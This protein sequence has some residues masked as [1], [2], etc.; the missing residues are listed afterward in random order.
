MVANTR[1]VGAS[2]KD[3][4]TIASAVSWFQA[5]HNF[6]TDGIGTISI[7]DSAEF[8][9]R[10]VVDGIAG[11]PSTSAYLKIT[12]ALP[13]RHTGVAGTG[14]ARV[15]DTVG[16]RAF[17]IYTSFTMIE[18]L[19]I[20]S[21]TGG[22]SDEAIRIRPNVFDVLIT[23]NLLWTAR[24][25]LDQDGVY[26]GNW[27]MSAYVDNCIIYGW[28]RAGI[29]MQNYQGSAT[30]NWYIDH[31]TVYNCGGEQTVDSGG[32]KCGTRLVAQ[33]IFANVY[34]TVSVESP[35]DFGTRT[36][37]DGTNNWAGT[38]NADSDGSLSDPEVSIATNAQQ[39]LVATDVS[40][41]SGSFAVFKNL[42]AG[43]EDLTLLDDAAGNLLFG[44]GVSRAG[45]E[46]DPRQDFTTD[47]AGNLRDLT[48]PNIGAFEFVAAA[49][50]QTPIN[51]SI[52][53]LLST[54][55]RLTWD[56]G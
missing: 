56:Q 38:N 33:T 7:E 22:G 50:V 30:Q 11:T 47:I 15:K 13:N 2:G 25:V 23:R 31:V 51:P 36:D 55:V 4:T 43:S 9:E 12:T 16:D 8:N 17:D 14:H 52:T 1:T 44:T 28:H 35:E 32:I 37:G 20:Q 24:T 42:T 46:P 45:S 39:N 26:G 34:N 53:N 41:I 6:D 27:A 29:N 5:N 49:S 19:E 18:G 54:S 21:D 40:Q 48:A 3:H 10:I